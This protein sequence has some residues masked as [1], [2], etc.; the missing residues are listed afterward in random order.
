MNTNHPPQSDSQLQ[1]QLQRQSPEQ[2]AA[3]MGDG[4]DTLAKLLRVMVAAAIDQ[5][6]D[7]N[8][9][10]AELQA[11]V[12]TIGRTSRSNAQQLSAHTQAIARLQ[13]TLTNPSRQPAL[14]PVDIAGWDVQ[15]RQLD[16]TVEMLRHN[17]EQLR[18]QGEGLA[19]NFEKLSQEIILRQVM[20]P[21]FVALAR[22][23]EAV[24]ALTGREHLGDQ[25]L[26]FL[27]N[28]IRSCLEDYGTE[29]IHPDDGELLDPRKHQPVQQIPSPDAAVH[30][31]IATTFNVGL[32]QGQRVI[33]P[34]RVGVFTFAGS[35]P[36]NAAESQ[37]QQTTNI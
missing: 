2:Y 25:D 37:I 31:H 5:T 20:D 19:R 29:L 27:L 16:K 22:L 13:E 18:L 23:Y 8:G 28:R 34:A 15:L 36:A 21:F 11:M 7:A 6:P 30:A 24:Y 4:G 10:R 33:Q 32:T 3:T 35:T 17:T 12:E 14:P 1:H 26:Q 9:W